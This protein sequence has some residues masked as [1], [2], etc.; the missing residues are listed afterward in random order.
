MPHRLETC[1]HLRHRSNDDDS[2]TAGAGAPAASWRSYC[3]NVL[4][5]MLV[6]NMRRQARQR[7]TC[8][9]AEGGGVVTVRALDATHGGT[10]LLSILDRQPCVMTPPR[11]PTCNSQSEPVGKTFTS[12]QDNDSCKALE[13][14]EGTSQFLE[15]L[16]N[17]R[18]LMDAPSL[19]VP[20]VSRSRRPE[21][22][23]ER[24]FGRV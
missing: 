6:S 17:M 9:P 3:L 5:K 15:G 4:S 13:P 1:N 10:R 20:F 22:P 19:P 14:Q 8:L 2:S 21:K 12:C 16:P 11:L 18:F 24:L 23:R 7:S